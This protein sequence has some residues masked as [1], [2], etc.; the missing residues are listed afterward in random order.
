MKDVVYILLILLMLLIFV[1]NLS[2]LY[3]K[4][5]LKL[6]CYIGLSKFCNGIKCFTNFYFIL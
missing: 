3:H 1:G 5:I 2:R 6:F 4:Y